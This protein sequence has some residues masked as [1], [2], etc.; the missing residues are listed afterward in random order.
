M[1]TVEKSLSVGFSVLITLLTIPPST[2]VD[3]I[4][5]IT[6]NSAIIPKSSGKRSLAKITE[7]PN[8]T[9]CVPNCW[10]KVQIIPFFA[11]CFKDIT[12]FYT[13]SHT[14]SSTHS[15]STFATCSLVKILSDKFTLVLFCAKKRLLYFLL[16]QA[17]TFTTSVIFYSRSQ[18]HKDFCVI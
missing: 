1:K 9:I 5:M 6:P 7:I 8:P 4:L 13:S 10:A 16:F 18:S 3:A 17:I 12:K 15:P 11:S 2:N 14:A